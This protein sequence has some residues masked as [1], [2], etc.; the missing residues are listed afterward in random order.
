MSTCE[1]LESR[2]LLAASLHNGT[3]VLSGTNNIDQYTLS[4][5][6]PKKISVT[7]SQVVNGQPTNFRVQ[8]FNSSSVKAVSF[9]GKG[10][11]DEVAI[12]FGN[13]NIPVTADG[14]NG[15]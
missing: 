3:L 5:L 8:L 12:T 11:N 6:I 14:G 15:D 13:A 7:S 10:G 9:S 2:T 4:N 1:A